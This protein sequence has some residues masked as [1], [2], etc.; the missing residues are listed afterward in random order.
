MRRPD[1]PLLVD[2]LAVDL[3]R[4]TLIGPECWVLALKAGL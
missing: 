4:A 2:L 1:R 3:F